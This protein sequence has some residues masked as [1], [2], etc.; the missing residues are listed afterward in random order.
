[1][2]GPTNEEYFLFKYTHPDDLKRWGFPPVDKPI[3]LGIRTP[4]YEYWK[5]MD[6]SDMIWLI[7]N[8][9]SILTS[10]YPDLDGDEEDG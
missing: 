6:A 3:E 1:M 9:L 5:E 4:D 10:A 7:Q 2:K 8:L